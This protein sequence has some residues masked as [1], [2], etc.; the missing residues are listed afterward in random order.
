MVSVGITVMAQQPAPG[1][2]G[3]PPAQ[4]APTGPR[5]SEKYKN[6]QVL[7]DVPAE[8]IESTMH[9]IEAATGHRCVD[10]H[11]QEANGQ[12]SFDKDDKR[13]KET[14][15]DM[16]KIV[17][18]VNDEFFNGR[19]QVSCATCHKGAR[20]V[21]T[22]PLAELLTPAQIAA[23]NQ[24]ARG[25]ANGA[26]A[27]PPSGGGAGPAQGAGAARGAGG[28]GG[29]RGGPNVPIDDVL[30]KYVTALGG[31]AALEKID[32]LTLTGT[33]ENR[34]GQKLPFTIEQKR[35]GKYR[36]TV[37]GTTVSTKAFDGTAGW[38]QTGPAPVDFAGFRLQEATRLAD[39]GLPLAIKD[40]YQGLRG[41][42]APQIDGKDVVAMSGNVA[43]DVTETLSFDPASGL[44]L[45]RQIVT[46]TPVGNLTEEV[47]YSDYRD[48]GGVKLPFQIKR[49]SWEVRDYL[50][51]TDAKPNAQIDD[52][53]FTKPKS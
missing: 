23:M 28:G 24:P 20:P 8:Q 50:T 15:R 52:A 45:R 11:V 32:S 44:L 29:G 26:P 37:Q 38:M 2:A 48:V 5:A 22:A 12:F 35:P 1:A 49:L 36:E 40:R 30:N 4:P 16:I 47:D 25:Q 39:L 27:G 14:A 18:T 3:A 31:R 6:I 43:A 9:F 41:A 10:C 53:R 42:R 13:E 34:A 7:K 21:S 19:V 33:L 17:K 46:H 51:V